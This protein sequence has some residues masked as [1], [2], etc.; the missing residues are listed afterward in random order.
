MFR[1]TLVFAIWMASTT[2]TLDERY[3]DHDAGQRAAELRLLTE[4]NV[5]TIVPAHARDRQRSARSPD[6]R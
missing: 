3:A 1:L 2:Q 5:R 4:T 6:E